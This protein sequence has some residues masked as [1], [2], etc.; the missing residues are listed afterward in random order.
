MIKGESKPV[1]TEVPFGTARRRRSGFSMLELLV[2]IL[3]LSLMAGLAVQSTRGPLKRASIQRVVTRIGVFDDALR[4]RCR[5]NQSSAILELTAG[6]QLRWTLLDEILEPPS[7]TRFAGLYTSD[8]AGGY[9][10]MDGLVFAPNGTSLTYAIS[11]QTT[12]ESKAWFYVAGMTGATS[13][14]ES[15]AKW[16]Q[17]AAFLW[18]VR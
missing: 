17:H 16:N 4:R 3:I 18:G 14:F 8:G 13:W 6:G 7:G 9:R 5:E 12:S 1:R 11:L 15:D 2:V 10:S